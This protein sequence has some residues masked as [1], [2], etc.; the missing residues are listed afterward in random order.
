MSEFVS[1]PESAGPA[2]VVDRPVT[3]IHPEMAG[4]TAVVTGGARGMG[5]SFT[6]ALAARG[7]NVLAA[8]IDDAA[9][10]ETAEALNTE[11]AAAAADGTPPGRIAARRIDVVD[12]DQHEETAQAA[13]DEFGSLD[14]WVNNAGVFPFALVGEVSSAQMSSVLD[15]NV[16]GVLHGAQAA[17]RHM[18]PGGA[19]VNMSSVSAVRVRRGRAAYCASKAAVA[20]LTESLA[21]ELGDQGLRVNAIAPGF[22]DTEMTR[23]LQDD[24]EALEAALDS[25][26]LHRVGSPEEVVGV[27]LFL[28]SD[29]SRYVTGHSIAVDG[30]SRH[31]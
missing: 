19:I 4:R 24:P 20:H 11:L 23:W 8:D 3:A 7:V 22:I 13:R 15:V 17:A 31:V 28:L 14:Y 25:V 2:R 1:H 5:R 18:Q 10:K 30:G 9:M 27:L 16:Q 12:P 29:S 26:P 6:R 21:V